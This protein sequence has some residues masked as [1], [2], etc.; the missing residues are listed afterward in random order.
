MFIVSHTQYVLYYK[1]ADLESR[2]HWY[3]EKCLLMPDQ[4]VAEQ[5]DA[6]NDVAVSF[7]RKYK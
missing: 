4:S 1:N 5:E 6:L 7:S 2:K 3:V